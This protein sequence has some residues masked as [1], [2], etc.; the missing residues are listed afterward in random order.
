MTGTLELPRHLAE[1][2]DRLGLEVVEVV[3]G[4]LVGQR[5]RGGRRHVCSPHSVLSWPAQRPALASSPSATGRVQG[6]QP[7]EA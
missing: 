1:D 5:P 7:I 6:A 4:E 2:V 3:E